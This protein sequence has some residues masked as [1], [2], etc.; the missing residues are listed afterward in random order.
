MDRRNST[1]AYEWE[2]QL[3]DPWNWNDS[4]VHLDGWRLNH[5]PSVSARYFYELGREFGPITI[6]HRNRRFGQY[7][8]S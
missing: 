6:P 4:H 2:E 5:N 1:E 7:H 8:K 3:A